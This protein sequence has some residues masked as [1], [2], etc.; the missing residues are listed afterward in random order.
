MADGKVIFEIAADP[1]KAEQAINDVTQELKQAGAKWEDTAERSSDNMTKSFN[2]AFNVE[3]IKNW[4]I[5][6]IKALGDFAKSAVNAASDLEEV[7]NVVDTT[8]GSSAGEINTW[9]QNAIKQFG[10]TETQAK[11]FASTMGAMMKS[12]GAA[13]GWPWGKAPIQAVPRRTWWR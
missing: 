5:A 10:L 2:A 11:R 4:A 6:G 9:A 8:F 7:Q 1:R 13:S 3:R 12:S